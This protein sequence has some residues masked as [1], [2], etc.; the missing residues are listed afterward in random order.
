MKQ[1]VNTWLALGLVVVFAAVVALFAW[2]GKEFQINV[3]NSFVKPGSNSQPAQNNGDK[4]N[5]D[6]LVGWKT[7]TNNIYK[8]KLQYP[9]NFKYNESKLAGEVSFDLQ[10]TPV[11]G[12]MIGTKVGEGYTPPSLTVY[13]NFS[14]KEP[15]R[16]PAGMDPVSSSD[17]KVGGIKAKKYEEGGGGVIYVVA[18]KGFRYEIGVVEV[19]SKVE[20]EAF[21]KMLQT[22]QFTN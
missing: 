5:K 16:E 9:A 10:G 6:T 12:L 21:A 20:K 17:T 19:T 18:N 4:Q 11:F 14:Q 3:Q 22:F 8:F 7:Y 15:L 1:K 2:S 13:K